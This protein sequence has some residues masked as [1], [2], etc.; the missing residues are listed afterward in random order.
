METITNPS[1]RFNEANNMPRGVSFSHSEE[2]S[3]EVEVTELSNSKQRSYSCLTITNKGALKNYPE[4]VMMNG[5]DATS[6][7]VTSNVDP[8]I[9]AVSQMF[10]EE[11]LFKARK[12]VNCRVS[13]QHQTMDER[14][15][16]ANLDIQIH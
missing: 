3:K 9:Q 13:A 4:E 1:F 10:V 14:K 5:C 7:V 2:D 12:E 15:V 11:L 6:V 8:E 16:I